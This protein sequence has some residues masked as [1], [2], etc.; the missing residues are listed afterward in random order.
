MTVNGTTYLFLG[1]GVGG[2]KMCLLLVWIEE[3]DLD[4]RCVCFWLWGLTTKAPKTSEPGS[5]L[6]I[7]F[8]FVC[9]VLLFFVFVCVFGGP[10]GGF[11][12]F[13]VGS[14]SSGKATTATTKKD[15]HQNHQQDHP[16]QQQNKTKNRTTKTK[17]HCLART[18]KRTDQ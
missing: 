4:A 17:N 8:L 16:I 9:T 5:E 3:V 6:N 18:L 13:P 12:G 15:S 11:G 2:R 1:V 14:K 7:D 10:G